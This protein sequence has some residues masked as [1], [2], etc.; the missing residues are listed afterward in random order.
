M[1]KRADLHDPGESDRSTPTL[2]GP[3]PWPSAWSDGVGSLK[4]GCFGALSPGPLTRPPTL[5]RVGR[6]T[7]RKGGLPGGELLP[8]QDLP[9]SSMLSSSSSPA[10]SCRSPGAPDLTP[11]PPLSLARP[12]DLREVVGRMPGQREGGGEAEDRAT[13]HVRTAP[14]FTSPG[15]RECSAT[16]SQRSSAPGQPRRSA[17]VPRSAR[18]APRP[19]GRCAARACPRAR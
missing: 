15:S 4:E 2:F 13:R 5:R 12:V 11:P 18:R 17:S 14:S 8:G 9:D 6:P 7:L 3:A 19:R 10:S 16:P 1:C